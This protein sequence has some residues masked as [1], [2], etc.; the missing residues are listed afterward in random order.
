MLGGNRLYPSALIE[1]TERLIRKTMGG[2]AT[3][4]GL[5]I[6]QSVRSRTKNANNR[7]PVYRNPSNSSDPAKAAYPAYPAQLHSK[8][9]ST[10]MSMIA[11]APS[12]VG[13]RTTTEQI[14]AILGLSGASH[15]R[16]YKELQVGT[17]N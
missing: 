4:I 7:W 3:M 13:T 16:E 10:T 12:K 8:A 11:N 17:T 14:R 2:G 1:L 6:G 15:N 9:S 5:A